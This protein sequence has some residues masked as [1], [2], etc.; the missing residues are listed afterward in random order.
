MNQETVKFCLTGDG[1][2]MNVEIEGGARD[3]I[4]LLANVINDNEEIEMVV[5]MALLA[6]HLKREDR[7]DDDMLG[8]M[9]SKVKPTA[10]A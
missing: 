7:T 8:E 3:L 2:G 9:F 10:Q 4:D 1:E 5:T 6:T